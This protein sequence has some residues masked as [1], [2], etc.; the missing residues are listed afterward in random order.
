MNTQHCPIMQLKDPCGKWTTAGKSS[1][2]P[3]T[4]PIFQNANQHAENDQ[5][6]R[7]DSHCAEVIYERASHNA[8]NC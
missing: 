5:S 1:L 4:V 2:M 6:V 7:S 8:S 3:K